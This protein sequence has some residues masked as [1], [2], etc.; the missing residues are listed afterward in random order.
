MTPNTKVVYLRT[1][2]AKGSW[3]FSKVAEVESWRET[4]EFRTLTKES[5]LDSNKLPRLSLVY[6]S[7]GNLI[8]SP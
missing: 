6:D 2:D 8:A 1:S 7:V 3:A 5:R 4:H